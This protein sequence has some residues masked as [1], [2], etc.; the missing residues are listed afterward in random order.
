MGKEISESIIG[1]LNDPE[2]KAKVLNE[3]FL[4]SSEIVKNMEYEEGSPKTRVLN[5]LLLNAYRSFSSFITLLENNHFNDAFLL[6]RKI[7]EILIRIEYLSVTNTF[8]NYYRE[9]SIEQAKMLHSL[10][11]SH[12]IKHVSQTALWRIRHNIIGECKSIYNDQQSGRFENTP[13]IEQMA[14]KAGMLVLYKKT[15]G[16]LSKFVHSNMSIENFYL[17]ESNNK[18]HYFTEE[19]DNF[20]NGTVKGAI[21]DTLYCF[22]Q[23]IAK[24]CSELNVFNQRIEQFNNQFFLFVSMDLVTGRSKSNV[25]VG[26]NL[27]KHLTG[28]DIEK[29][30]DD[31]EHEVTFVDGDVSA[32]KDSWT[33]LEALV[34]QKENEL[35]NL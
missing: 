2:Y 21:D 3:T 31:L 30:D 23:I 7:I 24:Y 19:V 28:I 33:K 10:I 34:S 16:A 4:L 9:R 27:I 6:T 20:N 8:D 14:E 22:Y 1:L 35:E 11:N 32:L 29:E 18:I 17:Y 15:Y 25:D 5:L 13:K 12:P 26:I